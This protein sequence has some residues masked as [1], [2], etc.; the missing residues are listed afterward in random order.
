MNAAKN[1]TPL[2]RL[3]LRSCLASRYGKNVIEKWE[4]VP[5]TPS[6]AGQGATKT[7]GEK[8]AAS[9]VHPVFVR[10][11]SGIWSVLLYA[12]SGRLRGG[13]ARR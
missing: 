11:T 12:F 8:C 3:P 4:S 2:T 1:A 6:L 13:D 10:R 7:H 5:K 9:G